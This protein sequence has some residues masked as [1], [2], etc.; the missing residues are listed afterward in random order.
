MD[1]SEQLIVVANA[2]SE[3]INYLAHIRSLHAKSHVA[4][5]EEILEWG[6]ALDGLQSGLK[7]LQ[8]GNIGGHMLVGS[9]PVSSDL[10]LCIDNIRAHLATVTPGMRLPTS[11]FYLID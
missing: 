4:S 9:P 11:L 8:D 6:K 7:T 2:I 5:S 1:S 3:G 10:I